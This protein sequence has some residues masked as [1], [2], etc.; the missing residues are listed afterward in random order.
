MEM[1]EKG[2]SEITGKGKGRR[3]DTMVRMQ[4]SGLKWEVA[5]YSLWAK[6]GPPLGFVNKVLL[7]NS[8][9]H[10]FI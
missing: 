1:G 3:A 7:A 6:F 10:L 9:T 8:H 4:G 5:I 2:K